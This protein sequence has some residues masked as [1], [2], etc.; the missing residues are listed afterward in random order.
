MAQMGKGARLYL[1]SRKVIETVFPLLHPT[2]YQVTSPAS[3]DYNCI[4]WAAS[5]ADLWWWPDN[6][7]IYHWPPGAPREETIN[8]FIE[9]Y[10]LSGYILCDN[11]DYEKGFEK[12]TIFVNTHGKPTHAARQLPSGRW[13]SKLGE[14]EDIEHER[15]D[16][17]AGQHYG[18]VAII[19]KR[20]NQAFQ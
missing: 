4:A 6:Q 19:M 10:A 13:T 8:A 17:V 2:N 14:L 1:L 5:S 16:D 3:P 11:P 9:A 15:L 12:I 18:A 20:P 7:Y